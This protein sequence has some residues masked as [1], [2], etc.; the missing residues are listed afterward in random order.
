MKN[1]RFYNGCLLPKSRPPPPERIRSV[2]EDMML[3]RTMMPDAPKGSAVQS[4]ADAPNYRDAPPRPGEVALKNIPSM[5]EFKGNTQKDQ[6]WAA[7]FHSLI[8]GEK[9]PQEK[10]DD[11]HD[12][13]PPPLTPKTRAPKDYDSDDSGNTLCDAPKAYRAPMEVHNPNFYKLFNK[14]TFPDLKLLKT[15]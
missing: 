1:F 8:T 5:S 11:F 7:A 3:A 4:R 13:Q 12:I 15:F 2:R 10:V 9:L 14:I 6:L